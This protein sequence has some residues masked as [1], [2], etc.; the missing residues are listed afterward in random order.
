MFISDED[1]L[2]ADE[3][4][5]AEA[6]GPRPLPIHDRAGM[7]RASLAEHLVVHLINVG[8]DLE[9]ELVAGKVEPETLARVAKDLRR[10]ADEI[11]AG[12]GVS[13]MPYGD[14]ELDDADEVPF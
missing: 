14:F 1:M 3:R 4:S 11:D 10:I 5:L 13:Q 7:R 8:D 2:A 9:R 6:P 12:K